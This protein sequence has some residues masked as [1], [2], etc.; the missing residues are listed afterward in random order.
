M[1]LQRSRVFRALVITPIAFVA[2]AFAVASHAAASGAPAPDAAAAA[3]LLALDCERLGADA[4]QTLARI[5][6]PRIFNLQGSIPIVTMEPFAKFLIDMGYPEVSLRDPEDGSLSMSSYVDSEELAG[7]IAWYYERD[8]MR[9]MLVGHSQ[10]GMLVL[11]TL[12]ELA[13]HF[14][15]TLKVYDPMTRAYLPRTTIRDPQTHSERPVIGVEVAFAAA[16]ATGTL[17][18]VLLLQW[19]MIPIL[20]T[21]PDT[22]V[23]FTGFTIAWD[24][25]AGN[26]ASAQPYE[27]TG[28][29]VVRNVLLPSTYSHLGAPIT[30]HLAAQPTTR[31]WI[32]DWRPDTENAPIPDNPDLDTRNILHAADLWFSIRRHWCREGQRWLHAQGRN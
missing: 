24:P 16:I 18:R 7:A 9:P 3:A 6:A 22:V 17:P 2:T 28:T 21:I 32:E 11:R 12:H 8:G 29:A 31:G 30:E 13:G 27:A 5:P 26:L 10:G 4:V 1:A 14:H 25:I 20:R 23:E 19:S 15:D